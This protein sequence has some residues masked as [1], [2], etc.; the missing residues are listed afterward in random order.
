MTDSELF[1][2]NLVTIN[3]INIINAAIENK[4]DLLRLDKGSYYVEMEHS[5]VPGVNWSL[6]KFRLVFN[7][8]IHVFTIEKTPIDL[9]GNFDIAFFF[10]VQNL[11]DVAKKGGKTGLA[12][13][14]SFIT[15]MANIAYAT[16]RGIIYTRC[17]GTILHEIILPILPTKDLFASII[18][19]NKSFP[20]SKTSVKKVKRSS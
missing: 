19:N 2:I 6:N 10:N 14:A 18:K 3:S 17:Q 12:L 15:S 7:C 5:F 13:E 4:T 9:H 20:K 16:S 11:Q 1:D 8:E